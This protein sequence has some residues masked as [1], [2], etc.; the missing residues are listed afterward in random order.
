MR[1]LRRRVPGILA[2]VLAAQVGAATVRVGLPVTPESLDP[3]KVQTG[4]EIMVV[5]AIHDALYAYDPLARA[6]VIVPLAA[7]SL[8]EV[9]S[10][11]RTW[12]VHV[13]PG[14]YFPPHAAFGGR[15]REL[16]AADYAYTMRRLMDP[17]L[18]SIW[19]SILDGK[20]AGLDALA[21]RAR[22]AGTGID[23]DAPVE[24]LEIVDSRTLRIRLNAPD[25]RFAYLLVGAP[26]VG[27]A[28]EVV[29]SEGAAYAQHPLG[30]GPFAV[31]SFTPGQRLTLVRNPAYRDLRFD[32]LLSPASRAS[33]KAHPM[34]GR[35]LP[36][37][38]RIEI[39][40]TSEAST[41]LLALMRD[42]L[43]VIFVVTPAKVLDQGR[44]K[45]DVARAGVQL[46]RIPPPGLDAIFFSMKDASVGGMSRE[47]VALRRAIAMAFDDVEWSR[48][49][50]GEPASAPDQWVPDVLEGHVRGYVSPNRFDVASA[51]A[52]LDRMGYRR[53]ADG[54]R[55]HPGGGAVTVRWLIGTSSEARSYAEFI[56][57]MLDRIGVHVAFEAAPPAERVRRMTQCAFGIALMDI[58][59]GMPDGTDP[60]ASF[61]GKAGGT[62]MS[63]YD[64]PAFDAAYERALELPSGPERNALFRTMQG[65]LDAYMPG[66][67]LPMPDVVVLT[68][69]G[70]LG[71]FPVTLA[72][73]P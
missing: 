56:K 17:R 5:G 58:S 46:V 22:K 26:L 33:A 23:Y 50:L 40:S 16:V 55:S 67:A 38:D 35:K 8:P 12:T 11:F 60:L 20:I 53:G 68:R 41:E 2:L 9:S 42:E 70:V 27:M 64:D 48:T 21:A 30:T 59:F 29:E 72:K 39:S 34:L 18:H 19:Q 45:A 37:A 28:R 73:S 71:P 65:Q 13:R 36:A 54:Y 61:Y 25:P 10:D 43:D 49:F 57:R 24:G 62:N 66:R 1:L 3:V 14:I 51:N 32:D 52:L 44:L 6:P 7:A 47:R 15:R 63:C 69:R 31:A 4:Q